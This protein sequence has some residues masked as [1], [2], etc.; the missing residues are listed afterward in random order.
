MVL[1]MLC[2]SLQGSTGTI[3]SPR[4]GRKAALLWASDGSSYV[5]AA[6]LLAGGGF[7]QV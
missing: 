1:G 5:A 7:A 6:K 3:R 2:R 4:R